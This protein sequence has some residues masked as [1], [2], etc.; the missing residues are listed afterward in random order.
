MLYRCEQEEPYRVMFF[1]N[2]EPVDYPGCAVGLCSWNNIQNTLRQISDNCN[3]DF[4]ERGSSS[5]LQSNYFVLVSVIAVAL[6]KSMI[7]YAN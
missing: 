7:Y 3:L 6:T 2:E 4:C 1:L 5:S